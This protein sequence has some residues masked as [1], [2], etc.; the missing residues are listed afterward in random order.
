MACWGITLPLVYS[1]GGAVET[2]FG[3]DFTYPPPELA[4]SEDVEMINTVDTNTNP[5]TGKHISGSQSRLRPMNE[6]F[7]EQIAEDIVYDIVDEV[8]FWALDG[9]DSEGAMKGLTEPRAGYACAS[10]SGFWCCCSYGREKACA[11]GS[12]AWLSNFRSRFKFL[13]YPVTFT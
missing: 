9:G 2:N 11:G 5:N 12:D 4:K 7:D 6:R 3:P 10:R 8:D 13:K 1:V